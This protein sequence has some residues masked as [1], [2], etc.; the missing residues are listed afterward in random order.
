MSKTTNLRVDGA[1]EWCGGLGAWFKS[2]ESRWRV[3]PGDCR[4]I[5]GR[6][7]YVAYLYRRANPWRSECCWCPVDESFDN[8]DEIRAFHKVIASGESVRD[9]K[10]KQ[11]EKP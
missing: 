10:D 7:F 1:Y 9:Y 6:L 5:R 8:Y 11:K 4:R 2:Y 3:R